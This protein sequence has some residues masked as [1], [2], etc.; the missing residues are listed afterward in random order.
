[1]TCE[2]IKSRRTLKIR[3]Y[4]ID[5]QDNLVLATYS[6]AQSNDKIR[7]SSNETITGISVFR[8]YAQLIM[9]TDN[10]IFFDE[11]NPNCGNFAATCGTIPLK[12]MK[13]FSDDDTHHLH[14]I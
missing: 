9:T 4:I 2:K 6:P 10:D 11:E 3:N 1:M 12:H 13:Y 14:D 8:S 5:K 7:T